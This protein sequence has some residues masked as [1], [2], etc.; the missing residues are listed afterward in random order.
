MNPKSLG[1][2]SFFSDQLKDGG[3]IINQ[4][5]FRVVGMSRTEATL[6]DGHTEFKTSIGGKWFRN[7]DRGEEEQPIIGDWVLVDSEN[8]MTR[9]LNR[10]NAIQRAHPYKQ[11]KMQLMG[12][13]LDRLLIVASC[14]E[15]YNESRI[16]RFLTLAT[17]N[18]IE[19]V[20]VLTK[21]DLTDQGGWY[22]TRTRALT[23]CKIY[24]INATNDGDCEKLQGNLI[25]GETTAL[26]GSSGVGKSTIV[27]SLFK[28]DVQKTQSVR[29]SDSKGRH[30]TTSRSLHVLPN[31]ALIID[32]PGIREIALLDEHV[33]LASSF[34]DI[35]ELARQCRFSNCRHGKE[36]DCAVQAAITSGGL[37]PRRLESFLRFS[38]NNSVG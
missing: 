7:R 30:T 3:A 31:G 17:S 37:S 24:L 28:Q 35:L 2:S 29:M 4:R 18:G 14:N 38:D 23:S 22:E 33:D 5:P 27:N 21:A 19:P 25:F 8:K 15:D 6:H 1:W 16:E 36:P 11:G 9:L 34:H 12:A 32:S 10:R 26:I 20:L 13:N